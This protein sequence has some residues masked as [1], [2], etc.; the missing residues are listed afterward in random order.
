MV[1]KII[2]DVNKALDAGAY[3]AALSLLLTLPDICAK[4]EYGSTMKNKER[5]ITWYEENIGQYD[6]APFQIDEKTMPYLSGEV[7][8]QLR[9]SLLHQGTPN[10]EKSKINDDA[11][12]IDRFILAVEEK[13]TSKIYA[14]SACISECSLRTSERSVRSYQVNICRLCQIITAT[15]HGY[16]IANREKFDFFNYEIVDLNEIAKHRGAI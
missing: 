10:V 7:V 4:A 9:C 2:N 11:C 14:D 12:K 5:Y 6:K 16:Y 8:Y 15:A 13:K 1:D 3:L